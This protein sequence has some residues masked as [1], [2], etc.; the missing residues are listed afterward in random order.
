MGSSAYGGLAFGKAT[1]QEVVK[2]KNNSPKDTPE[3]SGI[4][5]GLVSAWIIAFLHGDEGARDVT[6]FKNYFVKVLRFHGS[7]VSDYSKPTG[8]QI[9]NIYS[10][11][12]ELGVNPGLKL[13]ADFSTPKLEVEQIPHHAAWGAY[14]NVWEHAI[15]LAC[16]DRGNY[17]IM[18]PNY[19]LYV[20]ADV[21]FFLQDANQLIA[22]RRTHKRNKM[23]KEAQ[24]DKKIV[25][26]GLL[27]FRVYVYTLP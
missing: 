21:K 19:G 12:S 18:D 7:F 5:K 25:L 17:W 11:M 1:A 14:V 3:Q 13:H 20:Y 2:G 27:L 22:N 26:P 16:D 10:K 8:Y 9:E 23:V 24:Q 6:K 15:G 4:C